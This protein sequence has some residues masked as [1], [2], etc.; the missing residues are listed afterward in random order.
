[1]KRN[2]MDHFLKTVAVTTTDASLQEDIREVQQ[3]QEQTQEQYDS[4]GA[5]DGTFVD[6]ISFAMSQVPKVTH[7]VWLGQIGEDTDNQ[8]EEGEALWGTYYADSKES[9]WFP[10]TS[11]ETASLILAKELT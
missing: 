1:M 10:R 4:V 8:A 5:F 9:R 3:I 2:E 7:E 11:V 6:A